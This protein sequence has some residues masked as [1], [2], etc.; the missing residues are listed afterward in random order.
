M[1]FL[2]FFILCGVGIWL[3]LDAKLWIRLILKKIQLT[4]ITFDWFQ[5]DF[6]II[7]KIKIVIQGNF[8]ISFIRIFSRRN[9][10]RNL[11]YDIWALM[12]EDSIPIIRKWILIWKKSNALF[13]VFVRCFEDF[14]IVNV[15]SI[16]RMHTWKSFNDIF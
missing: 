6:I 3:E 1:Y 2:F 14:L 5:L 16:L 8:W 13:V 9:W 10:A 15:R 11:K 7:H 12:D 4:T